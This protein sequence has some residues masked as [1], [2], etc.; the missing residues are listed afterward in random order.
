MFYNI[1]G[2]WLGTRRWQLKIQEEFVAVL[3]QNSTPLMGKSLRIKTPIKTWHCHALWLHFCW[4]AS[5][6][7]QRVNN[8]N[9]SLWLRGATNVSKTRWKISRLKFRPPGMTKRLCQCL[10]FDWILIINR[11]IFCEQLIVRLL[12]CWST[13]GGNFGICAILGYT[14]TK[15]H[16]PCLSSAKDSCKV[17]FFTT[18]PVS[19]YKDSNHAD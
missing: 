16:I 3:Q 14:F 9:H 8:Q 2:K 17:D 18:I 15:M 7:R 12:L 10:L 4:F 5:T 19:A 11:N 1:L 6:L 13:A